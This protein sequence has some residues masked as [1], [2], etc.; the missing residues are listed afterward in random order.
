[1]RPVDQ[2]FLPDDELKK[3]WLL[4]KDSVFMVVDDRKKVVDMWR[5]EGLTVFQVDDGDF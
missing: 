1:M 5:K 3:G 4:N 2:K